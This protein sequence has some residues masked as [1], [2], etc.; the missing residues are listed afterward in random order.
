MLNFGKMHIGKPNIGLKI[1]FFGGRDDD[2]P[3]CVDTLHGN[4]INE[5]VPGLGVT[6]TYKTIEE[7]R[8]KNEIDLD[9][10]FFEV[11]GNKMTAEKCISL[12][13]LHACYLI[14]DPEAD[15]INPCNQCLYTYKE[16]GKIHPM[17]DQCRVD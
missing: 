16:V 17:C 15:E 8:K 11:F 5:A 9:S 1:P 4:K 12:D 3:A 14:E 2:S 7:E 6:Y 13:C 10:A